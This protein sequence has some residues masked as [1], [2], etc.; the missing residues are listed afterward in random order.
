MTS[1]QFQIGHLQIFKCCLQTR[2]WQSTV[3][4]RS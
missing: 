3:Y 2:D 4:C 1:P